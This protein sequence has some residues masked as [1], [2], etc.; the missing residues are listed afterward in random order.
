MKLIS[1]CPAVAST[2]LSICGRGKGSFGQDLLRSVNLMHTHHFPFF[3]FTTTTLAS[4]SGY[5]TSRMNPAFSRFLTSSLIMTSLSGANFL[6]FYLTGWCQ[7]STC[8]RCMITSG[9][10]PGMSKCDHAKQ[11]ELDRRKSTSLLLN[12]SESLD[13]ILRLRVKSPST[14]GKSS[15]SSTSGSSVCGAWDLT[16]GGNVVLVRSFRAV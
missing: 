5:W 4:H 2:S 12:P 7:G 16:C 14:R 13:P 9:S 6:R 1:W 3:F 8:S 11:S 15:M 10:I